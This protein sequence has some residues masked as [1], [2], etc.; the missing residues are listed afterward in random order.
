MF[1]GGGGGQSERNIRKKFTVGYCPRI[2]E[3]FKMIDK[4]TLVDAITLE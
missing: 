2:D 1:I 3:I 4:N